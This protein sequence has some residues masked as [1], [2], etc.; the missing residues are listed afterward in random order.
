VDGAAGQSLRR[1]FEVEHGLG[2]GTLDWSDWLPLI[3]EN[4]TAHM[5]EEHPPHWVSG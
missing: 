1:F 4:F 5:R 3:V 2:S